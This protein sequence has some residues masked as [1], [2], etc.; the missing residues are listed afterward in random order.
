MKAVEE[1]LTITI[2]FLMG[3]VLYYQKIY[4]NLIIW[5]VIFAI[6]LSLVYFAISTKFY[7]SIVDA[8]ISTD[9]KSQIKYLASYISLKAYVMSI[10]WYFL[11]IRLSNGYNYRLDVGEIFLTIWIIYLVV[12]LYCF[13]NFKKFG[14]FN[15]MED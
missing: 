1:I 8:P 11:L 5:E 15:E 2:G 9:K 3:I 10:G 7:N 12:Y 4:S 6:L 14:D 13:F